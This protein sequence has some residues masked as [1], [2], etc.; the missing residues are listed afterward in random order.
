MARWI[1]LGDGRYAAIDEEDYFLASKI[2]WHFD[3]VYARSNAVG[4]MHEFLMGKQPGFMVDHKNRNQLDN[5]RSN[6]R[7]ATRAQN[8]ANVGEPL[9]A[10]KKTIRVGYAIHVPRAKFY[11]SGFYKH[12]DAVTTLKDLYFENYGDFSPFISWPLCPEISAKER[13]RANSV[14]K[15]LI[16]LISAERDKRIARAGRRLRESAPIVCSNGEEYLSVKHAAESLNV[17]VSSI[18]NVLHGRRNKCYGLSWRFK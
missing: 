6:L 18:R 8:M 1:A 15:K 17:N 16:D 2:V 10:I 5:R 4:R 11:K 9:G 12:E 7:W 14:R 3:G 13:A